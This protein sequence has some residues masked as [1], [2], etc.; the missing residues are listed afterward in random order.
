M[1]AATSHSLSNNVSLAAVTVYCQVRVS[2]YQQPPSH[3][4]S[5]APMA[6]YAK[7]IVAEPKLLTPWTM[8][9]LPSLPPISAAMLTYARDIQSAWISIFLFTGSRLAGAWSIGRHSNCALTSTIL[10][11]PSLIKEPETRPRTRVFAYESVH[12]AIKITIRLITPV[13]APFATKLDLIRFH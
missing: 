4:I 12:F 5:N 8:P 13:F 9:P 11:V 6:Q 10:R 7:S 2:A 1:P 3:Q